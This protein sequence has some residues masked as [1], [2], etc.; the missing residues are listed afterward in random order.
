MR[1]NPT[2][3]FI[4][5]TDQEGIIL[6]VLRLLRSPK[7]PSPPQ[8]V[9]RSTRKNQGKAED[10]FTKLSSCTNTRTCHIGGYLKT[11]PAWSSGGVE[12]VR[13][14][15]KLAA[16]GGRVYPTEYQDCKLPQEPTIQSSPGD[17]VPSNFQ[18]VKYASNQVWY[19]ELLLMED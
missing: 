1:T 7:G 4:H 9:R 6:E 19:T 15:V 16:G 8:I 2:A 18:L 14:H 11:L 12:A 5:H 17:G 13:F 10:A 3:T